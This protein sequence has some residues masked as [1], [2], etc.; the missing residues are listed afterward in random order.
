M[1]RVID[2]LTEQAER[3]AALE[4]KFFELEAE[5]QQRGRPPRAEFAEETA[6]TSDAFR[7][8]PEVSPVA[9]AESQQAER[10]A[11]V[12]SVSKPAVEAPAPRG[13]APT[14]DDRKRLAVRMGNAVKGG[15]EKVQ[16]VRKA[17]QGG[18][19]VRPSDVTTWEE[20][21]ALAKCFE[22]IGV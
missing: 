19:I 10:A 22:S 17:L 18:M 8:I 11:V 14:E 16:V 21:D 13:A 20:H 1:K 15:A 3:L 12:E 5:I 9:P 2:Y 6:T 7:G 4:K